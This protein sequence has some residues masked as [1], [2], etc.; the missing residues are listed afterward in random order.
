MWRKL[1]ENDLVSALSREEVDAYRA[2]FEIDPVPEL[3]GQTTAYVRGY[4]RTNGSVRMDPDETTVPQSCV[5]PAMDY[6][7]IS[8]LKRIGIEPNE[9]RKT[10]REEAVAYFRDIAAGKNKPEDFD[11]APDN[12]QKMVA[13][14]PAFSNPKPERL[15]D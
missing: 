15:L 12:S 2:D 7:V 8:I 14:T 9:V 5:G 1:T 6:L 4:I 13:A 10:A 11:L 3:L